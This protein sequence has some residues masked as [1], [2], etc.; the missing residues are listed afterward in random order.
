[1][2]AS[3]DPSAL[4]RINGA[5]PGIVLPIVGPSFSIG[6]DPKNSLCVMNDREVSRQHCIIHLVG[7]GLVI[8]DRSTNG[9]FL[10]GARVAG[11]APMPVPSIIR[12]GDTDLQVMPSQNDAGMAT[13][14]PGAPFAAREA[15]PFETA[16][17]QMHTDALLVVDVI[18][19]THL[20][21]VDEPHFAKLV[22]VLGRT[23]EQSFHGEEA[24]FLKCTG[25]G[26]LA[27]YGSASAALTAA[28]ALAPALERQ[29]PVKVQLSIALHWGASHLTEQ[30]DRIGNH[31]HAV[32]SLEKLRH[33]APA[34][35]EL[36]QTEQPAAV[37]VMSEA[38]RR[39]LDEPT[40]LQTS[41]LGA[42][43]LKGTAVPIPVYLWHE[44]A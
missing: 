19:S 21:E 34:L 4:I 36:L 6:R 24:P 23:L 41:P 11:I 1:M 28:R 33:E 20:I 5:W 42:H 32:F 38:F 13:L 3:T 8:E 29:L 9:T 17:I 43:P 7:A 18:D 35:R 26:F 27:C 40:R 10:N 25:D 22:L 44:P 15:S 31:V 16:S 30:G 37:L 14:I 2:A 39:Q 12:V